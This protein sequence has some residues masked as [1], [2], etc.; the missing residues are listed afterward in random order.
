MSDPIRSTSFQALVSSVLR[1]QLVLVLTQKSLLG[2]GTVDSNVTIINKFIL[3]IVNSYLTNT[4]I[5]YKTD[6]L[7]KR[8]GHLELVP[9][10]SLT[11]FRC[12]FIRRSSLLDKH[13]VTTPKVSVLEGVDCIDIGL[14][15]LN[16]FYYYYYF[17]QIKQFPRLSLITC[18]GG[19]FKP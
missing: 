5:I 18:S 12:L 6:T 2:T 4:S 3:N 11:P 10:F 1:L 16:V 15:K 8:Y 19:D 14:L 17:L 9:A 7:L 13:I